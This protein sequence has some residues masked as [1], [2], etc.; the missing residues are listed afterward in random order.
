MLNAKRNI[1][2]FIM[3]IIQLS[4]NKYC[5][6]FSICFQYDAFMVTSLNAGV[7]IKI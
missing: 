1:K 6:V 7:D 3:A 2:Q 4:S 5:I